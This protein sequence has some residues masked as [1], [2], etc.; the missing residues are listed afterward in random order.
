MQLRIVELMLINLRQILEWID[1]NCILAANLHYFTYLDNCE[2]S[3]S[4]C[5]SSMARFF[6]Q[7][8]V[9]HAC[10]TDIG[11]GFKGLEYSETGEVGSASYYS[12]IETER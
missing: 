12:R 11:W 10:Y 1:S 8:E 9:R 5:Q 7:T 6:G 4:N 2:G 3:F